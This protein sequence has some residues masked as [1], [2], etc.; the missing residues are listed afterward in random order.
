[1]RTSWWARRLLAGASGL[2]LFAAGMWAAGSVGA[3]A[4][5]SDAAALPGFGRVVILSH[6]NDPVRTPLFPGDPRFRIHT[7]FTI[8]DDGF[9]LEVVREG[10]HTGTH[11]SAPCHFHAGAAC[12]PDL[13]ASDLVLPAAVIDIRSRVLD[14]PDYVVTIADLKAWEDDHGQLPA[15]GAVLLFTGCSQFWADGDVDGEPNYYNCGSG[16][17]G[18]HQPGFSRNAVRWLIETGV[19][20]RTG[21]L[22]TDTFGPDPSSDASFTPTSLTLDRHRVTIEN[23]THLGALPPLGAW[24]AL[25]SPRNVNGSGAPG[26]V[27]AFLP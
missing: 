15:G 24:V 11:Y 16:L 8:A 18:F 7:A 21:A 20:G 25:G 9:F 19:L 22:G 10:M 6:V 13:S 3:T 17:P 4:G 26:T 5:P 27:F 1:M 14:D 2:G 23:L 12:M